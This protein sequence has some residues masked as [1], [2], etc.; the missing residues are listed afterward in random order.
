[1][2]CSM[3][4]VFLAGVVEVE[5]DVA[6]RIDDGGD[7]FGGD[8]VGGVGEAAEKELFDEY[9]F[10]CFALVLRSTVF[11]SILLECRCGRLRT[12]ERLAFRSGLLVAVGGFLVGAG[13]SAKCWRSCLTARSKGS[14]EP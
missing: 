14:T 1:M 12:F 9:W 8:D 11:G 3:L 13:V 6:L 10:H 4:E 2:M 7:A 5:I